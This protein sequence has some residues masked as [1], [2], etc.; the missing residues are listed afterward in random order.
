LKTRRLKKNLPPP[1]KK[2]PQN[3]LRKRM[4]RSQQSKTRKTSPR[5]NQFKML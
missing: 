3:R 5:L 2:L 4:T 1:R